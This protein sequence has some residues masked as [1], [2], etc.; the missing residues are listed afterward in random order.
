MAILQDFSM[1][2][3]E[4]VSVV[5]NLIPQAPI[6]GRPIQFLVQQGPQILPDYFGCRIGNLHGRTLHCVRPVSVRLSL[7]LSGSAVR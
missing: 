3:L 6:G 2:Y 4:D 5:F 1:A 7:N